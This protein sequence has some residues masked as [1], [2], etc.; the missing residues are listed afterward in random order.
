MHLAYVFTLNGPYMA[1]SDYLDAL[2]EGK[3]PEEVVPALV[4]GC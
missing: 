1:S 3:T 4:E 2:E